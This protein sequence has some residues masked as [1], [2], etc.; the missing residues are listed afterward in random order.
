MITESKFIKPN[1]LLV[2]E[3]ENEYILKKGFLHINEIIINKNESS[4]D[5]LNT[6]QEFLRMGYISICKTEKIHEDFNQL[7]KFGII[8]I[9]S[10]KKIFVIINK[11]LES[12]A[13][14]YF[15]ENIL[16]K[17]VDELFSFED[18]LKINENKD[19]IEIKK[20]F[21]KYSAIFKDYDSIYYL[22]NLKNISNLRAVNR[23]TA[24][25]NVELTIGFYDNENAYFT[26]IKHGYTGCFECLER[27]IISK[28]PKSIDYYI[29]KE[30]NVINSEISKP[31]VL[32]LFSLL[33][34][35]IQNIFVYGNSSLTGQ[36]IHYYL[37]NFEY[38]YNVNRRYVSCPSCAGINNVTFEEQNIRSVNIIKEALASDKI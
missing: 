11:E 5:F 16:F 24:E 21:N 33:L 9:E 35:D 14:T 3:N 34:K 27:H 29:E 10:N 28:F 1:D 23:L 2:I 6:F 38:S 26:K 12:Y 36:V 25:F 20:I 37:P 19:L 31:E 15:A 7:L 22:E 4:T 13:E 18:I 17:T 30:N 8:N 32:F